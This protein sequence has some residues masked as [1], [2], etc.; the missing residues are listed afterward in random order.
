MLSSPLKVTLAEFC[1]REFERIR[2]AFEASG[3]GQAAVLARSQAVDR[4]NQELY[5]ARIFSRFQKLDDLCVVALGGYGR[6]ELFPHSDID[7]LF[8]SSKSS[9]LAQYREPIGE[10]VRS[11]WDLGLRASQ[12]C[13]TLDD[14]S[15]LHR[16][17]LEFNVAMVDL[18]YVA[19]SAT[20]FSSLRDANLPRLLGKEGK[21]LLG[22]LIE[23]TRLRHR[24]FS[25]TIFHLEPNVKEVPGGFRDFHVARWLSIISEMDL[26]GKWKSADDLFA[27]RHQDAAGKAFQFL[28]ATRCFLHYHQERDDNRLSYELQEKAA[29]KGIGVSFGQGTNP[30]DWMRAYFRHARTVNRLAG[31]IIE[32]VQPGRLALY[33]LYRDWRS[34]VSNL[35]FSAVRGRV[36]LRLPVEARDLGY[37]M[38]LFE[39]V[40]RHGLDLSPDAER[41]A[42]QALAGGLGRQDYPDFWQHFCRILNLPHAID[43]LRTMHRLGWLEEFFPEFRAI[44]ALVIRDFYHRYTVDEHS[45]LTI[46]NLLDLRNADGE[47]DQKFGEILSELEDVSLLIFS[48]LFHD[49]GK[50]MPVEHHIDGSLEAVEQIF[51]RLRVKKE[52]RQT[53]RFLIRNHLEMST[54]FQRR[55]IFDPAT[56]RHLQEVVGS[57]N[58]L[59]MLCLLTYADISSVNP[60]ALTP[61]K[62]EILWTLYA[63]TSNALARS[64]DSDRILRAEE[65]TPAGSNGAPADSAGRVPETARKFLEGFPKRYLRIH[66][67]EE[68]ETHYHM[69][70]QLAA[71]PVQT[72][73]KSR[74]HH[75]ELMVITRDRPRLFASLT[76][77]LTA[78]GMNIVAAE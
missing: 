66:T 69:A 28:A 33:N 72:V 25:N 6:Q 59:K 39:F 34:R 60:E 42:K 15:V 49:V 50:G 22:D 4:V 58:R 27:P 26:N 65:M 70:E 57:P 55:D 51:D 44:D 19:G 18:R 7:L 24:K 73:L 46:Q 35:D 56:V 45:L 68:I 9:T 77:A 23:M 40:G 75:W 1:S 13:R 21:T 41:W 43:A 3:D 67:T 14:C 30:A 12:T 64:L 47:W 38:R 76:G 48:L 11:L 52:D 36:F 63:A 32:E 37:L 10:F 17:N 16:D 61:W 31:E 53:I 78:W 8:M 2:S 29:G 20:L 62:A 71:N 5:Q 74:D 54:A